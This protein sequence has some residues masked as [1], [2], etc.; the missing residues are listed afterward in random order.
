MSSGT[1]NPTTASDPHLSNSIAYSMDFASAEPSEYSLN[2]EGEPPNAALQQSKS[3]SRSRTTN[4]AGAGLSKYSLNFEGEPSNA[5]LQQ[6]KSTSRSRTTSP[7]G[8]GPSEYSLT[9]EEEECNAA[10]HQNQ[11]RSRQSNASLRQRQQQQKSGNVRAGSSKSGAIDSVGP[12]QYS[13]DFEDEPVQQSTSRSGSGERTDAGA[14]SLYSLDFEPLPSQT[15]TQQQPPPNVV[16]TPDRSTESLNTVQKSQHSLDA[17]NVG[18]VPSRLEHHHPSNGVNVTAISAMLDSLPPPQ[19]RP[20]PHPLAQ[21]IELARDDG[22]EDRSNEELSTN[23]KIGSTAAQQDNPQTAVLSKDTKREGDGQRGVDVARGGPTS[24]GFWVEQDGEASPRDTSQMSAHL[25]ATP[26]EAKR[27]DYEKSVSWAALPINPA[28]LI[29]TIEIKDPIHPASATRLDRQI[30]RDEAGEDRAPKAGDRDRGGSDERGTTGNGDAVGEVVKQKREGEE[31]M[32]PVVAH[33]QKQGG[34]EP[35]PKRIGYRDR[36]RQVQPHVP[37]HITRPKHS[38]TTTHNTTFAAEASNSSD[39]NHNMTCSSPRRK[40]QQQLRRQQLEQTAE[41]EMMRVAAIMELLERKRMEFREQKRMEVM[42]HSIKA[43]ARRDRLEQQHARVEALAKERAESTQAPKPSAPPIPV[44]NPIPTSWTSTAWYQEILEQAHHTT[45]H[46]AHARCQAHPHLRL[47]KH[48][49]RDVVFGTT[50]MTGGVGRFRDPEKVEEEGGEFEDEDVYARMST[51]TRM[52]R[53][54]RASLAPARRRRRRGHVASRKGF[55]HFARRPTMFALPP[56]P[57]PAMPSLDRSIRLAVES[58]E[59]ADEAGLGKKQP[60]NKTTARHHHKVVRMSESIVRNKETVSKLLGPRSLYGGT[61]FTSAPDEDA[62]IIVPATTSTYDVSEPAYMAEQG[63][64][65]YVRKRDD[66]GGATH[67]PPDGANGDDA[68]EEQGGGDGGYT[69][70]P[71]RRPSSAAGLFTTQAADQLTR[72]IVSGSRRPGA[73]RELVD[74]TKKSGGQPVHIITAAE[75]D[76]ARGSSGGKR[77]TSVVNVVGPVTGV[78]PVAVVPGPGRV[79]VEG[80][81]KEEQHEE[82]EGDK[83]RGDNGAE[84]GAEDERAS[85]YAGSEHTGE[86]DDDDESEEGFGEDDEGSETTREFDVSRARTPASL[87]RGESPSP[88]SRHRRRHH[89]SSAQSSSEA[90]SASSLTSSSRPLR[91]ALSSSSRP[92]TGGRSVSNSNSHSHYG[93]R[94]SSRASSLIS[95]L[96]GRVDDE[97]DDDVSVGSPVPTPPPTVPRRRQ[98]I[99]PLT[100]EEVIEVE[101]LKILQ[102]VVKIRQR[103]WTVV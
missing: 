4:P 77:P 19:Q 67:N 103:M 90:S 99:A 76:G 71:T 88:R 28:T 43:R 68:C 59:M 37:S 91:H 97:D 64:D 55:A 11:R 78:A 16:Q 44:R 102:P 63:Y 83:K 57:I 33:Q 30:S 12:S 17:D 39:S 62:M 20:P 80:G 85:V 1:K 35:H 26:P 79:E 95:E 53:E 46:T 5:A 65:I 92:S 6:S 13:L 29:P 27:V 72:L 22:F 8:A 49:S 56:I 66:G 23:A 84:D 54:R 10:P 74:E 9:F 45:T 51:T 87:D 21:L 48:G 101:Q 36:L 34:Q 2:F 31:P 32:K 70:A 15:P 86:E 40:E 24:D 93:Y 14:S 69:D 18:P 60:V 41:E 94:A 42:E 7:A 61:P 52:V 81:N 96:S 75:V 47:R 3:K 73:Q 100:M 25:T 38:N 89:S 50:L 98:V 82:G 58:E